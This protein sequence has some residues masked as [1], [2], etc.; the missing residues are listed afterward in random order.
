MK[1]LVALLLALVMVLSL[2]AGCSKSETSKTTEKEETSTTTETP[3]EESAE[4]PAE[5][6]NTEVKDSWL[7]EEK[8]TLTV[9]TYD[10]IN[11]TFEIPS[12]DLPFW[13]W[14]EEYTN[15]HIE[16]EIVPLSGYTEVISTRLASGAELAD[17]VNVY[18][19]TMGNNAGKNG[20]FVNLTDYWDTCFQN[21]QAYYE[22]IGVDYKGILCNEDGS[23]YN[24][25][26]TYETQWGH[27]M[28][29]YN[30]EWLE[31]VNMEV[32]DT[33]DEFTELMYAWKEAG[34]LNGNGDADEVLLTSSGTTH[35]NDIIG[36]AFGV[37]QYEGWNATYA[38]ENGEVHA[39]YT[40]DYMKDC[41]AYLNSLYEDGILD[42][43]IA[44]MNADALSEKVAADRVGC[45][46]YYNAFAINY[47]ALTS[48]G[49]EDPYGEH[50][51][52]GAPLGSEY[53]GG[54]GY[55]VYRKVAG[56]DATGISVN[57]ENIELAAKWLDTLLADPNVC[58]IR[59]WGFE[60]EDWQ[61]NEDGTEREKIVHEDGTVTDLNK[62][63]CGQIVLPHYQEAAGW[64]GNKLTSP[65]YVEQSININENYNWI[66][67]SVPQ[68]GTLTETE[69]EMLD[70][71]GTDVNSYWK[72][73]R[74]K[75]IIG[76]ADTDADWDTF[77]KNLEALGLETYEAVYQSVYDR[78]K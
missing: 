34:D 49:L 74:D 60:G 65:W 46:I 2:F 75:F 73:M 50:Y 47:G 20:S 37:E 42:S 71:V 13:S 12:N 51:T 67:P 52:L 27:V 63:G 43:E 28:L 41:L 10:R 61:W 16:W 19:A 69:Q 25:R 45:F 77:V 62:L 18:D 32:P 30:T 76:E 36:G 55:Y 14:L 9:L 70:M 39:E 57:S 26:S 64:M 72:E 35:I 59:L 53:N 40:A 8:T 78:T 33:L 56:A 22:S 1:K 24:I 4:T 44:S 31:A 17:I 68:V 66:F 54:T 5:E 38:D 15:V 7:C 23:L 29:M 58:E 6:T 11:N 21:T 3:A 48:A